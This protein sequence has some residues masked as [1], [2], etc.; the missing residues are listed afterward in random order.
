MRWCCCG[1]RLHDR[2]LGA[3]YGD[4]LVRG[5]RADWRRQRL[6]LL[7]PFNTP[8]VEAPEARI[9]LACERIVDEWTRTDDGAPIDVIRDARRFT[10]D[11]LWRSFFCDDGHGKD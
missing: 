4:N 9:A 10:L 8:G 2:M 11:S 3:S 7:Q 6:Q 5:D 1:A